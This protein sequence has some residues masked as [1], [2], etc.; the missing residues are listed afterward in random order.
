MLHSEEMF[1]SLTKI[2]WKLVKVFLILLISVC[3]IFKLFNNKH[4]QAPD[5]SGSDKETDSG[6]LIL[7]WNGYQEHDE[8][9]AR[10]FHRM[11]SGTNGEISHNTV[12]AG[13]SNNLV[14]GGSALPRLRTLESH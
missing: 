3:I 10:V 7:L 4:S 2:S 6:P 9:W 12:W 11:S 13:R 5:E 1:K 8:L 14:S